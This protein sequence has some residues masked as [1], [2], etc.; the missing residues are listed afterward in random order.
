M[1]TKIEPNRNWYVLIEDGDKELIVVE[2]GDAL[3]EHICVNDPVHV[4]RVELDEEDHNAARDVLSESE[5]VGCAIEWNKY[6]D[7]L[8]LEKIME[9][10]C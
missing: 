10:K 1:K 2:S 8:G 9:S 5:G 3:L 6:A 4:G 7:Q